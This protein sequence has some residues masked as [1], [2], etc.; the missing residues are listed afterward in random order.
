MK[1]K[2]SRQHVKCTRCDGTGE[3]ELSPLFEQTF[4]L[5]RKNPGRNGSELAT[6]AGIKMEAMANRL[7]AL[8]KHGLIHG[9]RRGRMVVWE[10]ISQNL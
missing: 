7:V 9:D 10:I 8:Q 1:K 5:V 4:N 6:L 2:P 3:V